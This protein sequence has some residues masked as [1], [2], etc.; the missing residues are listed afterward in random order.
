[1]LFYVGFSDKCIQVYSITSTSL[2]RSSLRKLSSVASESYQALCMSYFGKW[3][4][5]PKWQFLCNSKCALQNVNIQKKT[6]YNILAEDPVLILSLI[7]STFFNLSKWPLISVSLQ[8]MFSFSSVD[9]RR[10]PASICW[11]NIFFIEK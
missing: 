10:I 6:P 4:R 11:L 1:M 9:L 5:W 2:F 7:L 8:N 3:L